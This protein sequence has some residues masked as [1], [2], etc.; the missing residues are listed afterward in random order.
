MRSRLTTTR[1]TPAE[2]L[3]NGVCVDLDELV[4]LGPASRGLSF[5]ARQPANSVLRG[6]ASSRLRGPGLDFEEL[7]A[8]QPGDDI[9]AMDWRVTA[10]ARTPYV[11]VYREEK[12]RPVLVVVDQR[13]S[14][15]FGSV[16]DM[17]SVT[18]ARAA[19]IVAHRVVD[20]GDRIGAVIF[21]DDEVSAF[22]PQ[23]SH[24]QLLRIL[25]AL[26]DKNQALLTSRERQRNSAGLA[27]ALFQARKLATHDHL[28]ILISDL[29][30]AG[31][32]TRKICTEIRRRNDLVL[33]WVHDPLEASLPDVGQAVLGDGTMQVQVDTGSSA[34]RARFSED[35]AARQERA[36][37]LALRYD[38][39]LLPLTTDEDIVM[40][41]RRLLA[42]TTPARRV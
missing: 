17:K 32:D 9:R 21:S 28:V 35:V 15:F 16:R 31:D 13:S 6:R 41:L 14:M 12:E 23:R 20:G 11:R 36:A 22:Q 10:R 27:D 18:A 39:P 42:R 30:D 34:L 40:Q 26:K 38:V 37:T 3:L 2:T 33:L 24:A 8:Y 5:R 1:D 25:G 29:T 4:R 7:R 19:A